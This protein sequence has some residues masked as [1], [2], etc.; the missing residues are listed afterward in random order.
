MKNP[1]EFAREMIESVHVKEEREE[2][3]SLV[4]QF[5][6]TDGGTSACLIYGEDV[7]LPVIKEELLKAVIESRPYTEGEA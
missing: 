7:A 6:F 4:R 1:N 5:G 2:C 3:R